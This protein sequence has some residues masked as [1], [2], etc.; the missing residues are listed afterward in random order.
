MV[1]GEM[2]GGPEGGG[3]NGQDPDRNAAV[4]RIQAVRAAGC[5]KLLGKGVIKVVHRI[6]DARVNNELGKSILN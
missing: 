2:A 3:G 4:A 5:I 6:D 1:F